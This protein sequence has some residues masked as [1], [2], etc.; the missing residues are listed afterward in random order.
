MQM[1]CSTKTVFQSLEVTPADQES[2]R[3]CWFSSYA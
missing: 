2:S 1:T 3:L